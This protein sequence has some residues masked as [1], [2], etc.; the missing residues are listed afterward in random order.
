MLKIDD[1][2]G[3]AGGCSLYMEGLANGGANKRVPSTNV[4][5]SEATSVATRAAT[6]VWFTVGRFELGA[7]QKVAKVL[8]SAVG[9][10]VG[11]WNCLLEERQVGT[12]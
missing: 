4:L 6:M 8:W 11:L 2:A 10:N 5:A 12:P 9:Y 1:I 3:L 7:E